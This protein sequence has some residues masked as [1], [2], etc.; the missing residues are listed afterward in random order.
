M[1]RFKTVSQLVA[2]IAV[3][4]IFVCF[5]IYRSGSEERARL[6]SLAITATTQEETPVEDSALNSL[7]GEVVVAPKTISSDKVSEELLLVVDESRGY[8][9]RLAALG[10]LDLTRVNSTVAHHIADYLLSPV[11]ESSELNANLAIRNDLLEELMKL[12]DFV[13]LSASV[14]VDGVRDESLNSTWREY[15]L[16]HYSI[17][18][19]DYG[20]SK[21]QDSPLSTDL[22]EILV[23]SLH[24]TDN[25]IAGTALLNIDRIKKHSPDWIE[26]LEWQHLAV[27]LALDSDANIASRVPAFQVL[28]AGTYE[29]S[30]DTLNSVIQSES[31]HVL[32]KLALIQFVNRAIADG[33][34]EY[35]S[36]LV[37]A[38]ALDS[39]ILNRSLNQ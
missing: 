30:V 35:S 11:N 14:L 27:K 19:R 36:V 12:A 32:L 31:E 24:E 34:S 25:G 38:K 39:K 3:V 29:V 26:D 37:A 28:P 6:P 5:Y 9:Q 10:R 2:G 16:Q 1:N 7:A 18:I 21:L 33:Q 13:E 23:Q 8:Q 17:L 4:A 15:L 22:K 20:D